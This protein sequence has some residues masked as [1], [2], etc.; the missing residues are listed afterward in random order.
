MKKIARNMKSSIETMSRELLCNMIEF[1]TFSS[2][3]KRKP[4][5]TVMFFYRRMPR[6]P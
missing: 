6:I 5:V 3:V 1:W 2:N 4:E